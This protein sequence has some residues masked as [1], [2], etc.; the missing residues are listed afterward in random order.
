[1]KR[2]GKVGVKAS[3]SWTR[4]NAALAVAGLL[5]IGG[6]VGSSVAMSPIVTPPIQWAG[7]WEFASPFELTQGG[8]NIYTVPA[9]R[10]LIAT[11]ITV[12][13][14]GTSSRYVVLYNSINAS[15]GTIDRKRISD[16][17][18][19]PG[20]VVHLSY[21]TGVGFASGQFVCLYNSLPVHVTLRGFLFTP[22][23]AS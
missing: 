19:P 9:G 12:S 17:P 13:N 23:P 14:H 16:M 7:G 1:M 15:C 5:A 20:G 4:T 3:R 10:S 2:S 21:Q 6:A 18:V 22:A 8:H 11:D